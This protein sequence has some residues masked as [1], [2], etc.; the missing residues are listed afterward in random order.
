MYV[1]IK[2]QVPI[3]ISKPERLAKTGV[4]ESDLFAWWNELLNYLRQHANFHMY[5]EKGWYEKWNPAEL[6]DDRIEKL[7]KDDKSGDLET[8]RSE[9]NNIITVIAG[10]CSRD[11]YMLVQKQD[12]VK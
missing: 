3:K 2:R 10:S 11:Q 1:T 12:Y 7:H 9:L 4:T 6:N 8:R 5:K